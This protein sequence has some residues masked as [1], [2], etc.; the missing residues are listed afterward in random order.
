[1]DDAANRPS[2]SRRFEIMSMK[3]KGVRSRGD[4]YEREESK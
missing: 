1:M 2:H 3:T 4:S